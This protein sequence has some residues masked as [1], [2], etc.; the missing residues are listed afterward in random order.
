MVNSNEKSPVSI[1]HGK[2]TA[3]RIAEVQISNSSGIVKHSYFKVSCINM[4]IVEHE[5]GCAALYK[6]LLCPYVRTL[7]KGQCH[8]TTLSAILLGKIYANRKTHVYMKYL[9]DVIFDR[10][11]SKNLLHG[12]AYLPSTPHF[13]KLLQLLTI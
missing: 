10:E 2:K 13:D 6:G 8:R 12:C 11:L 9:Q 7:A 3:M 5:N 1:S 4:Y